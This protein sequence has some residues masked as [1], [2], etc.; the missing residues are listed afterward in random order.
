MQKN[1]TFEEYMEEYSCDK[2]NTRIYWESK[3]LEEMLEDDFKVHYL[4]EEILKENTVSLVSSSAKVGKTTFSTLMSYAVSNGIDFLGKKTKKSGVLYISKDT[5]LSEFQERLNIMKFK[6]NKNLIFLFP[7]NLIISQRNSYDGTSVLLDEVISI[8]QK[9]IDDLRLVILDM[10][11]DFRDVPANQEYNNTLIRED[12][13][14]LKDMCKY[15]GINIVILMHNRKNNQKYISDPLQEVVGGLQTTGAI[16]GSIL[17][18]QK[19]VETKFDNSKVI[20]LLVF[21]RGRIKNQDI[22]LVF[23]PDDMSL[24]LDENQENIQNYSDPCVG[25]I[26]NFIISNKKFIGTLSELA[27]ILKLTQSSNEIRR[28]LMQS[29]VILNQE[30][31]YIEK[32]PRTSSKRPYLIYLENHGDNDV[33]DADDADDA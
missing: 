15:Y 3:S 2:D 31:I 21:I 17:C 30:N 4:V 9:K 33:N 8:Y 27:S 11:Q 10:F 7:E 1:K 28:H 19:V 20:K 25:I 26:R 29:E 14:S 6:K 22:R 32:L 13:F 12:I 24:F 18:L 5:D 16:N 23:N